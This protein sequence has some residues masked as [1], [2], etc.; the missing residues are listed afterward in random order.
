[1]FAEQTKF[2]LNS[3]SARGYCSKAVGQLEL[4]SKDT[5][6]ILDKIMIEQK[7]EE[8]AQ[9]KREAQEKIARG[10][11]SMNALRDLPEKLADAS[12]FT[13]AEIFFCE[14]E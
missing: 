2:T 12:D 8:A 10:G 5:K 7:A 14:G 3:P 9:R 6:Q 11:K 13:D 4:S 1:M